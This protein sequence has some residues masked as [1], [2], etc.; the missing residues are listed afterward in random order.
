MIWKLQGFG[1]LWQRLKTRRPDNRH[2]E[3]PEPPLPRR[4]DDAPGVLV[5]DAHTPTPD[6]D[7]GSLR[8][9]A[10]LTALAKLGHA[11]TFVPADGHFRGRYSRALTK[12]G[13]RCLYR[14][15]MK[16]VTALLETE[17]RDYR[18]VILSRADVA[19]RYLDVARRH[20]PDARLWFDTVD[21]QFLREQRQAALAGSRLLKWAAGVRRIQ[22]L[23]LARNADLTLVVSPLEKNLLEQQAPDVKVALLSNIHDTTPTTTPFSEREGIVFISNFAHPP[24]ADALEYF[25][26]A[27]LPPL[28]ARLPEV[29]IR[30]VGANP[31]ARLQALADAHVEFTGFVPQLYPLL[32]RVRV[33]VAPLRFGSGVKGKIN[34]CMAHGVPVVTTSVGAEGMAL[35]DGQDVL[36]A[37]TAADFAAA[38]ARIHENAGL[39][40]QLAA[41]GL[42]NIETNFSAALAQKQLQTLLGDPPPG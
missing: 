34:T 41:A 42:H 14:P 11:V 6:S 5:I 28:R 4:R 23:C 19:E 17:G 36:I 26:T 20:C 3:K 30:I 39:W 9:V 33:S 13:I 31:P 1:A 27:I 38:V 12:A 18:L 2:A 10:M 7:S 40:S 37:D 15:Y 29:P 8:M 35:V 25:L 16:S 32:D 24:N 22:E 21:L